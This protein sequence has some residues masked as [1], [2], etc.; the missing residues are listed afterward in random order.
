MEKVLESAAAGGVP[1]GFLWRVADNAATASR[2]LQA[3]VAQI[4]TS[5]MPTL[6]HTGLSRGRRTRKPLDKLRIRARAYF[7]SALDAPEHEI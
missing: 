7:S 6:R 3:P 4:S 2:E 1:V 5:P